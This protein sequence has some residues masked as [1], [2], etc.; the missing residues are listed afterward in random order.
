M[1]STQDIFDPILNGDIDAV[2][3][4]LYADPGL[5][6]ARRTVDDDGSPVKGFHGESALG[7]ATRAGRLEI[8]RLLLE[9]GAELYDISR[10]G[11]PAV[12]FATEP[13]I[14]DYLLSAD[15]DVNHRPTSAPTY[16]LGADV[17][18]AAREGWARI[19][20][21]HLERDPLA[22]H[23]RG[24]IGET[25]LHWAAHNGHVEVV[26][27]LL[28]A[29]ATIEANEIGLYGGKPLHWA[30]EHAPAVVRFLLDRGAEVDARNVMDNE[31]KGYT[32]LIMGAGEPEDCVACARFL[33]DA[34]ADVN[35]TAD[36]GTTPLKRAVER[37]ARGIE[38][39]LRERGAS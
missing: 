15:G 29:G 8:I 12:F 19:V 37:G 1:A 4:L 2:R 38:A 7:A 27:M 28:D 26:T 6:H 22:V 30:A 13:R 24:V 35:A 3:A 36:D 34:G 17:N 32:P 39:L 21:Q 9:R 25:P 11:Y 33:L 10:W 14:R 18:L 20:R 31:M 16:G 5:V 23:R